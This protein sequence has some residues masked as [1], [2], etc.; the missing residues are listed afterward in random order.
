MCVSSVG[1]ARYRCMHRAP[2]RATQQFTSVVASNALI[3][4][5]IPLPL[6]QGQLVKILEGI[7]G[8]LL[9]ETDFYATNMSNMQ[10]LEVIQRDARASQLLQ[11]TKI[12][13]ADRQ[14]IPLLQTIDALASGFQLQA[15]EFQR[16]CTLTIQH[17]L[18]SNL[19]ETLIETVYELVLALRQAVRANMARIRLFSGI[20]AHLFDGNNNSVM[21]H[22]NLATTQ[23]QIGIQQLTSGQS[24]AN[25]DAIQ[26]LRFLKQKSATP[27]LNRQRDYWA[28]KSYL[29]KYIQKPGTSQRY[30]EYGIKQIEAQ[31]VILRHGR[32]ET[33]SIA[34]WRKVQKEMGKRSQIRYSRTIIF[35]IRLNNARQRKGIKQFFLKYSKKEIQVR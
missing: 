2:I 35:C 3:Q 7:T 17:I 19:I 33:I 26:I 31:D 18:E 8:A 28:T 21:S 27:P 29:L 1:K 9:Q 16:L 34:N 20:L 32:G 12:S 23:R 13:A 11:L 4:R 14:F 10:V 15:L 6:V 22:A 25:E 24:V 30:P 5:T